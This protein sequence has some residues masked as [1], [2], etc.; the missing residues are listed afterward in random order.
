MKILIAGASGFIGKSLVPSLAIEH[1][2]TVLGRNVSALKTHFPQQRAIDWQMLEIESPA[3]Y[4]VIINL[5]GE[6]I[7]DKR[8]DNDQKNKIIQSRLNT[9]EK[10]CQWVLTS[11]KPESLRFINASAVGIYGLNTRE[12][13]E[14]TTINKQSDCFSQQVVLA[15]ESA[16][17]QKLA[18][19]FNYTFAR[20]GVVLKKQQG[21]LKKLEM[22][23]KL[24][25]AST[26]GNGKQEISWVHI[27]DL[28]RAIIFIIQ[29]PNLSGPVN[30]VAPEVVTQRQFAKTL[31][32]ALHRPCFF[33]TPGFLI[34]LLFGQMGE[35]LLLSGQTVIA[36]RLQDAGFSF[37][38][39]TLEK[40]LSHEYQ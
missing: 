11:N 10:L 35:E 1:E 37:H 25:L 20:F 4:Q 19:Q 36:K 12:N 8:W 5:C 26:L 16:I 14:E 40:A 3:D 17:K 30:I 7:A 39:S 27:D 9:T 22:P 31:A 23:Y 18:N 2:I 32:R 21:M 28:V 24:G 13:T 6:N 38:Y 15:W 33:K 29:G 34:K